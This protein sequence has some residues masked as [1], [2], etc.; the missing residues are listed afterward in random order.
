[1]THK[2]KG[3]ERP[4][5]TTKRSPV[6]KAAPVQQAEM[7]SQA[8]ATHQG[9]ISDKKT[10][11]NLSV[12]NVALLIILIGWLFA[13]L[14]CEPWINEH[15]GY[16]EN[17]D[18][19]ANAM[20]LFRAWLNLGMVTIVILFTYWDR[21]GIFK[22]TISNKIEEA[23]LKKR[24]NALFPP[25]ALALIPFTSAASDL[26]SLLSVPDLTFHLL[27]AFLILLIVIDGLVA[28]ILVKK[29]SNK[30]FNRILLTHFGAFFI[31]IAIWFVVTV[32]LSFPLSI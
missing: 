23:A 7:G 18:K 25:F 17:P 2:R 15:L 19:V 29:D 26:G 6:A 22:Q 24:V 11:L 31:L 13:Y 3:W 27:M 12:L 4:G 30:F 1:M 9:N 10:F 32:R 20:S 8:I 14:G 21:W 16:P 28:A 5:S